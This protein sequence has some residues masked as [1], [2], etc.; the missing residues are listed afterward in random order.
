MNDP[1]FDDKECEPGQHQDKG[2]PAEPV[3][4]AR[5]GLQN[6]R[7]GGSNYQSLDAGI[8]NGLECSKDGGCEE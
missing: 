4:T 1:P 7:S 2:W 3:T 8:Q 5:S 6:T